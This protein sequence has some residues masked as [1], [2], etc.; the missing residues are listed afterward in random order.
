MRC[1]KCGEEFSSEEIDNHNLT[2]SYG[3]VIKTMKI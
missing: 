2:C 1:E 3:L